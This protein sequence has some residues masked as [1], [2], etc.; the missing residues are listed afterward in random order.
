MDTLFTTEPL[1]VKMDTFFTTEP[2][3]VK[4][5]HILHNQDLGCQEWTH[6]SQQSL[7]F[8]TKY[9]FFSSLSTLHLLRMSQFYTTEPS[10]VKNEYFT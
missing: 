2:I 1:V 10:V 9:S 7:W 8:L 4:N 5:G 3:V 6:S